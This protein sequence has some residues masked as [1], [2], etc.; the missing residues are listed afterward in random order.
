M[1][2]EI[3]RS[4]TL[5]LYPQIYESQHKQ[6]PLIVFFHDFKY[7]ITLPDLGKL[8]VAKVDTGSS[9]LSAEIMEEYM[10]YER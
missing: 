1:G 7:K 6:T 9:I 3:Y 2:A 5:S 10:G 4:E 8:V